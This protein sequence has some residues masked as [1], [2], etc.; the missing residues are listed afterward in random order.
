MPSIMPYCVCSDAEICDCGEKP[1]HCRWC[2][3]DLSKEQ[4]EK[5]ERE[6]QERAK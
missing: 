1:V 6:E 4:Q 2:A 3:H 5:L